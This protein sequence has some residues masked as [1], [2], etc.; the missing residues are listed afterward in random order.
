MQE[1]QSSYR[2]IKECRSCGATELRPILDLGRQWISD[3]PLESNHEGQEAVPLELILCEKSAGG[4]GLLQLRHTTDSELLYR[5]YWYRSVINTSMRLALRNITESLEAKVELGSDDLVLDIGCND[6][7]LLRSY[8][9]PGLRLVGF[10][11]ARNIVADA[12]K[13]TTRIFNTFFNAPDFVDAFGKGSAKAITSIAMFYDLDDP[14]RVVADVAECLA[15]EGVWVIQ[16][17]YLPTMLEDTMFDNIC[18]E[19]LEYYSLSSLEVLLKR[20]SLEIADAELNDVNGG[21]LRTYIRHAGSGAAESPFGDGRVEGLRRFEAAIG[22]DDKQVYEEFGNRTREVCTTI[23]T[24]IEREVAAGKRV[25]GYG[26]STKGN[27]LLQLAGFDSSLIEAIA[28]RNPDKWGRRTVGSNIPIIS[29]EEMRAEAPDYL[30]ALPW[31]FLDEF[32]QREHA[33]LQGGGQFIAPLPT[34]RLVGLDGVLP[35]Q[36]SP[37]R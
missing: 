11:P 34:P 23:K 19:H 10:E 9:I 17:A 36:N 1:Q 21:S 15:P 31:H 27:T 2:Q 12:E 13:D 4:C 3:F 32:R 22:L 7:T 20:N 35:L 8:S 37:N 6:G 30:L 14:N 26:A 25:H 16:M 33:F 24:F 5:H 28:E 29:E 18:H